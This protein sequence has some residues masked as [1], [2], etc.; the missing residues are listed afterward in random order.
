MSPTAKNT[1]HSTNLTPP[2]TADLIFEYIVGYKSD[3]DGLAPDVASIGQ[4]CGVNI[5]T[6]RYHLP[7]LE[8]EGL[9]TCDGRRQ[10][11]VTGG[12]WL[13]PGERPPTPDSDDDPA[14]ARLLQ[15]A[16][17]E[18][19][20]W[21]GKARNAQHL[22]AQVRQKLLTARDRLERLEQADRAIIRDLKAQRDQAQR[23][24][25]A[26]RIDAQEAERRAQRAERVSTTQAAQLEQIHR[27]LYKAEQRASGQQS[28]IRMQKR[29]DDLEA[30]NDRLRA[31]LQNASD[32]WQVWQHKAQGRDQLPA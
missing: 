13:A 23:D 26:A 7:R 19:T 12:Q 8:N 17:Y 4:A 27:Q 20:F 32:A 15:D 5:S 1:T 21:K 30:E 3:H 14:V 31:Q 22:L 2:S 10:I 11:T 28:V 29:I 9:I 6:V 18:V 25:S 24:A 16:D